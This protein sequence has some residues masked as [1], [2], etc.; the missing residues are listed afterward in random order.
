MN[1]FFIASRGL[2][3][4]T[5]F[6]HALISHPLIYCSHGRDKPS[7]GLKADELIDDK[8]YR[9]DRLNYELWQKQ[10]TIKAYIEELEHASSRETF[11]GNIHGYILPELIDK[12]S[13]VN[14]YGKIPIANMT[15]D[16]ISFLESYTC[17]VRQNVIEYPEKYYLE[18]QPRAKKNMH[19]FKAF[20]NNPETDYEMQGFIEGCT[21]LKKMIADLEY[22]DIPI[23]QMEKIT[24][25]KKYFNKSISLMTNDSVEFDQNMID[26][27]FKINRINSHTKKVRE[28]KHETSQTILPKDIWKCWSD[29][30][31]SAFIEIIGIKMLKKHISLGYDFSYLQKN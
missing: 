27:I 20:F 4:S 5:W 30:K 8:E 1:Y 25:N 17:L 22:D 14:L 16:P 15:R 28:A 10:A 9:K 21:M 13:E 26:R 31:K 23:I 7:R 24:T 11:L 19:L 6:C 3:A 12:L 18:H 2:T 29:T